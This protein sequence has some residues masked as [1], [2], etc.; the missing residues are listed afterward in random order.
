MEVM[1]MT[2]ERQC[3]GKRKPDFKCRESCSVVM[4]CDWMFESNEFKRLNKHPKHKHCKKHNCDYITQNGY[5]ECPTC[6]I[7]K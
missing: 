4:E 7:E 2:N 1:L 5:E 6:H 3:Y